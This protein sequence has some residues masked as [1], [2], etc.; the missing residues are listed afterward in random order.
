MCVCMNDYVCLYSLLLMDCYIKKLVCQVCLDIN[1]Q[2]KDQSRVARGH[3][4][5]DRLA[6]HKLSAAH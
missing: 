2:T 3:V 5:A 4:P 1:G 6:V